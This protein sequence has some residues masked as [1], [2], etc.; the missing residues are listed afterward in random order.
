MVH[1]HSTPIPFQRPHGNKSLPSEGLWAGRPSRPPVARSW[2]SKQITHSRTTSRPDRPANQPKNQPKEQ[3]Q[4]GNPKANA[5]D[6]VGEDVE[7][8]T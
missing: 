7:H 6:K 5:G 2:R 4:P 3:T 1:I 8:I